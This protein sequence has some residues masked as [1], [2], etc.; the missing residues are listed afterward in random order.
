M[1]KEFH[2]PVLE[3]VFYT[4]VTDELCETMDTIIDMAGGLE[5]LCK[6]IGYKSDQSIRQ[7]Y[8]QRFVTD[9][10]LDRV[11]TATG[12][13][14]KYNIKDYPW[15]QRTRVEVGRNRWRQRAYK[16]VYVPVDI[17]HGPPVQIE[18]ECLPG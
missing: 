14:L 15:Y 8:S 9:L 11:L 13:V 6:I 18:G 16:R 1:V 3:E 7:L 4:P 5:A 12:D 10:I 2:S 17:W